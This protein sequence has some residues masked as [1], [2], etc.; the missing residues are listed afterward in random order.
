MSQPG[1]PSASVAPRSGLSA[2]KRALLEQQLKGNPSQASP[3]SIHRRAPEAATLPSYAQERLWFLDRLEGNSA[4]YHVPDAFLL[5]GPCD[6][7]AIEGVFKALI[8]RH[9]SLRSRFVEIDGKPVMDSSIE[10]K[11]ET[12]ELG[13]GDRPA[14]LKELDVELQKAIDLRFDLAKGPLIRAKLFRLDDH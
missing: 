8:A 13:A 10:F 3:Q 1:P 4:E 9:E 7:T 12:M 2:A 5:T 11:L 14:A 6:A